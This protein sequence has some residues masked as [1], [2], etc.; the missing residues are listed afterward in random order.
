M[1]AGEGGD[2]DGACLAGSGLVPVLAGGVECESPDPGARPLLAGP[3]VLRTKGFNQRLS[4]RLL[5]DATK[6]VVL[7]CY[8]VSTQET[9]Y[10]VV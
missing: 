5:Q 6:A 7:I 4:W 1:G 8:A 3:G 9:T 10:R 2:S